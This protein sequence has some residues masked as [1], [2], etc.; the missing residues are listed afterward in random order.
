MIHWLRFANEHKVARICTSDGNL[1]TLV[2]NPATKS[3]ALVTL[4]DLHP[5][6][7][8]LHQEGSLGVSGNQ[9]KAGPSAV[10]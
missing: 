5:S 4:A 1:V 7:P 2:A 6:C 10:S 8:F 9:L 3:G